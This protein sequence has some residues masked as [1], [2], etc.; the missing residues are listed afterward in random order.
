MISTL[1]HLDQWE[2]GWHSEDQLEPGLHSLAI[3]LWISLE[4]KGKVIP[5]GEAKDGKGT[6]TRS[7]KSS[8]CVSM[9]PLALTLV[10]SYLKV[11]KYIGSSVMHKNLRVFSA[12]QSETGTSESAQVLTQKNWNAVLT[13]SWTWGSCFDWITSIALQPLSCGLHCI[14]IELDH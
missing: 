13:K 10:F 12:H 3:F 14:C 2:S 5:C 9:Q 4:R 7:G 6:R 8:M 1:G 11:D